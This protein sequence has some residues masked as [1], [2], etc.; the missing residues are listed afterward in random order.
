MLSQDLRA[1]FLGYFKKKGHAIVPS[2]PTL[3]HNDPTLLFTNAGMNQFKEVFLGEETRPYHQATSAQKC[4]RVGGKHNDLDNVGHT[5]RHMTFFEMLGNFSFGAYAKKEAIAYA[6][7]VSTSIFGFD[8]QNIWASVFEEDDESFELWQAWLP[9]ER[10]VRF[11]ASE[12]FWSMGETGPCGPCSELLLDR[13]EAFGA[14]TTPLEDT[15]GE[16]YMEFWNLVFMQSQR[17]PQG[18]LIPLPQIAVDTG[19]GLE[20][21]ASLISHVP[22][23]FQ[24]DILQHVIRA[25]E[26]KAQTPYSPTDALLAP[27]FHVIADHLRALS[28]AIADGCQPGNTEQGYVLRK[29]LR[30]AVR[31]GRLLGLKDPFLAH[32]LPALIEV[33]GADYPEL[34]ASERRIAEILT[35][36]EENFDRTLR[37]GGNILATIIDRAKQSGAHQMSGADAFKLKDTYGFPVE[38]IVLIAKDASLTVNLDAYQILEEQAKEKSRLASKTGSETSKETIDFTPFISH[39]GTSTFTGYDQ[40]D[41][42]GTITGILVNGF[43][44][45][46]LEAG[47]K[48]TLFLDETP[49]YAEKGGQVG[50]TGTLS[51]HSA[52]FTVTCCH[53]PK[54]HLIAH[55]GVLTQG[56]LIVGEPVRA[57]VDAAKRRA[58]ARHHTAT[59]LLHWALEKTLGSHIKQAGSLVEANRLRFDFT[60]HKALTRELLR[61]VEQLINGK[62]RENAPVITCEAPLKEVQSQ[63]GIKQ[64]FGDKYGEIVRVVAIG[65]YSQ[66]LCGGTHVDWAGSIGLFRIAKESSIGQGVRRIEA[67]TGEA[68][69]ALWYDLEDMVCAM[70]KNLKTPVAKISPALDTLL[71]DNAA[72]TETV[73]SLRHATLLREAKTLAA[74]A[75]TVG[76]LKML[77]ALV[78]CERKELPLLADLIVEAAQTAAVC[79]A[80]SDS[81]KCHL[82]LKLTPEGLA[83]GFEAKVLI[84]LV[85]PLIQ[86]SGGGK[87]E[88]AQ[89][90]GKAPSGITAAFSKLER[91]FSEKLST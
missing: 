85:S 78:D 79:L 9:I 23:V 44:V 45:D 48:G 1:K 56:T 50:D 17:L 29:I 53:A 37:R 20:R 51:H 74:Q 61:T 54:A 10:I 47:Q 26:R 77:T 75:K 67:V 87:K 76:P 38:E 16:R 11:G 52:Q 60:H 86:G 89:A 59:H 6:F 7:E 27:A 42:E 31:Y 91:V 71:N 14:A 39:H 5:S 82:F 15:S 57:T 65:D 13:G 64:F 81:D 41:A 22:T 63:D 21:I 40:T 62:I 33:M 66:E 58:I 83:H 72:L 36:E 28:F 34:K 80:I 84:Q 68:A 70:A 19:A 90:G 35:L 3:P 88:T 46:T 32:L 73:R 12:N 8:P 30:R 55:V 25:V 2:A 4:I 49:F 24:T 69:E 43:F 18:K